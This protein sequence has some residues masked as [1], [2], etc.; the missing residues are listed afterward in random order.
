MEQSLSSIRTLD[1]QVLSTIP[2][3]CR[4]RI[5]GATDHAFPF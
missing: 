3:K 4:Q 2:T 1:R 5:P